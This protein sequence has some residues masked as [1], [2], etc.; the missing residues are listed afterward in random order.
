MLPAIYTDDTAHKLYIK[1][2][3]GTRLRDP[4]ALYPLAF[5][6][7]ILSAALSH[8]RRRA[9][10]DIFRLGR[11]P[12][13]FH[14]VSIS[15]LCEPVVNRMRTFLADIITSGKAPSLYKARWSW[16]AARIHQAWR[17]A[18]LPRLSALQIL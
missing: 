1:N 11:L 8:I 13:A 16:K 10:A 12:S 9:V 18:A 5:R 6:R 15:R 2:Q 3:G 17:R 14:A 4:S 7:C